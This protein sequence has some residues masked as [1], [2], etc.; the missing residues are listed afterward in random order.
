MAASD[1]TMTDGARTEVDARS[2]RSQSARLVRRAGRGR[3]PF[4]PLGL[5]PVAGIFLLILFG[6]TA[7]AN[8]AIV[9]AV[10]RATRQALDGAGATWATA[11]VSG[12]WVTLEG[13]PP[14]VVDGLKAVKAVQ[15]AQA[16]TIFGAAPPVTRVTDSF[17]WSGQVGV[18]QPV[19]EAERPVFAAA[20]PSAAPPPATPATVARCEQTLAELLGRTQIQFATASAVIGRDSFAVLDSIAKAAGG[21]PGTLR[22]EGHTDSDGRAAFNSLLSRK[23]AQAVRAA[24]MDRGVPGNRLVVAGYGASKPV[25]SNDTNE[26]RERNRRIEMRVAPPA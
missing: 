21:C 6:M 12:Q 2:A 20:Q 16:K 19:A 18:E 9:D 13:R 25:A 15:D 5:I 24:L 4:A 23:R 3:L 11:T 1:L 26:G 7:F 22:I 14:T 17:T 10:S 8:G